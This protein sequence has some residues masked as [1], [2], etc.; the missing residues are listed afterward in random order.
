[1]ICHGRGVGSEVLAVVGHFLLLTFGNSN[2]GQAND[3]NPPFNAPFWIE[4]VGGLFYTCRVARGCPIS[5]Q[6]A[7]SVFAR[8][9]CCVAQVRTAPFMNMYCS[10]CLRLCSAC[11]ALHRKP[12]SAYNCIR[13]WLKVP[14]AMFGVAW[15]A[16]G[17]SW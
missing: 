16:R 6:L 5:R 13:A 17:L 8:R 12:G 15:H 14:G 3:S 1:M 4:R 10:V 9:A 11:V 2:N 7:T